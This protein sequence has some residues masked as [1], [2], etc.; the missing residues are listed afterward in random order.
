MGARYGRRRGRRDSFSLNERE[1]VSVYMLAR[2][3][4]MNA[5]KIMEKLARNFD[6]KRGVLFSF[7]KNKS[8]KLFGSLEYEFFQPLSKKKKRNERRYL[9]FRGRKRSKRVTRFPLLTDSM[10]EYSCILREG[11]GKRE[12]KAA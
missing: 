10:I 2:K 11:E 6:G 12:N 5:S 8:I 1:I 3:R 4:G 9:L 7:E